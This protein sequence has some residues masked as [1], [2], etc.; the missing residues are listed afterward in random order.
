MVA[1]L[2][3]D[4][5]NTPGLG[6][7][8]GYMAQF[9]IVAGLFHHPLWQYAKT[10]G[11]VSR[12]I[13]GIR[14]EMDEYDASPD[15]ST[16]RGK[17]ARTCAQPQVKREERKTSTRSSH[18]SIPT[19]YPAQLSRTG[20]SDSS[21]SS[22]LS[23]IA[24]SSMSTSRVSRNENEMASSPA[25]SVSSVESKKHTKPERKSI[26]AAIP[27][28][29][30]A[31]KKQSSKSKASNQTVQSKRDQVAGVFESARGAMASRIPKP[32]SKESNAVAAG[33]NTAPTLASVTKTKGQV[34]A[35]MEKFKPKAETG[36]LAEP[37]N[38][39]TASKANTHIVEVIRKTVARSDQADVPEVKAA[40][41][42]APKATPVGMTSSTSPSALSPKATS[43]LESSL[44]TAD[45]NT[46]GDASVSP[47]S[48]QT[49]KPT[50]RSIRPSQTGLASPLVLKS[51]PRAASVQVIRIHAPA[52]YPQASVSVPATRAARAELKKKKQA[53]KKAK[54]ARLL[55]RLAAKPSAAPVYA[56]KPNEP[57]AISAAQSES[58]DVPEMPMI[59]APVSSDLETDVRQRSPAASCETTKIVCEVNSGTTSADQSMSPPKASSKEV[60][61]AAQPAIQPAPSPV[62]PTPQK[63]ATPPNQPV[64]APR[65]PPSI[66]RKPVDGASFFKS[67][68]PAPRPAPL[69]SSTKSSGSDAK[70]ARAPPA[71][72]PNT[73]ASMTGPSISHTPV[74]KELLAAC[75][76]TFGVKRPSMGTESDLD[77]AL[78][79]APVAPGACRQLGRVETKKATVKKNVMYTMDAQ[80]KQQVKAGEVKKDEYVYKW[81]LDLGMPGVRMRAPKE[82]WEGN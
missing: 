24:Q 16:R 33:S 39:E 70:Q 32:T 76:E 45:L 2:L 37:T 66:R 9:A 49:P 27:R 25:T 5:R 75:K 30:G 46:C 19:K 47:S 51:L 13:A 17:R 10:T 64:P 18:S 73:S 48:V 60:S 21:P 14:A 31:T 26:P 43:E 77:L 23:S 6:C 1:G 78:A 62:A 11:T 7:I 28:A 55:M 71:P 63:V 35:E 22:S 44:S 69:T 68:K 29:D 20:G 15:G 81:N 42:S 52:P 54:L 4:E 40:V 34:E 72:A 59:V 56:A 61:T 50:E 41:A 67:C 82:L 57:T 80:G 12:V 58:V 53:A 36:T 3:L 8:L 38:V 74:E 79:A 65:A